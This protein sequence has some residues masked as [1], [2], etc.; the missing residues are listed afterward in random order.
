MPYRIFSNYLV[1]LYNRIEVMCVQNVDYVLVGQKI[2]EKRNKLGLTQ[3]K[4]AEKCN[5][6][7]GYIAHIERGSKSLS[8][9]TAVKISHVL[10]VSIDYLLMDEIEEQDRVLNSLETELNSLD[11]KQK[12]K[13]IRFARVV[14]N[15][16][17]EL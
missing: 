14:I 1:I 3:E 11:P 16:I 13:F 15:N 8:L 9:E 4:L 5:L 6:S 2:K 12:D 10:N 7:V 17:D